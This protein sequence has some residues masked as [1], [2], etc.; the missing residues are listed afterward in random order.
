MTVATFGGSIDTLAELEEEIS[1]RI[2]NGAVDDRAS[3]A[4]AGIRRK[5]TRTSDEI[6]QKLD[7]L[8]R[9]NG[10][11]FSESFVSQRNGHFTLPVRREFKN[12][13]PGTLVDVSKTGSTCFIE[14]DAVRKLRSA[15]NELEV[16]EDGEVRRVLYELT[17]LIGD[18]AAALRL[19]IEAVETID[20]VF[21][22]G[23]TQPP[24]ERVT[25]V[26]EYRAG[27]EACWCAS[28]AA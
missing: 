17:A 8:L 20:F 18:H 22:K 24:N 13:V 2:V 15:L 6:R 23:K 12:S 14:P 27:L 1:R 5:M 9:K 19:N 4:L 25:G 3:P 7:A 28:S 10:R 21:A 26:T 16:E 11:W